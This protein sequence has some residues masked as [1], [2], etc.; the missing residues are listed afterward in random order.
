MKS[1]LRLL[2]KWIFSLQISH[3]DRLRF[4]GPVVIMPNHV[5]FLDAILLYSFLPKSA[6]FVVNLEIAENPLVSFALRFCTHIKIDPRNPY[7]LRKIIALVKEDVPVILFPEGRISVTGSMMKMYTGAAMVA[8]KTGARVFP[9]IFRGPE[10]SKFSRIKDKV[11]SLWFPDIRIFV[12]LPQKLATD[13]NMSFRAQKESLGNGLL[14]IMQQAMF[15]ARSEQYKGLDFFARLAQAS[16]LHGLDKVI[17]RDISRA[18]TYRQLLIGIYA[19]SEKIK[20]KIRNEETIVVG[21][22]MPNA[23]AHVMALFS[24]FKLGRTPAVFNFSTGTKNVVDCAKNAGVK[25]VLT[26]R[27]FV[28]KAGLGELIQQLGEANQVLYMEDIAA[29]ISPLDKLKGAWR[30]WRGEQ[31]KGTSSSQIIL[32]TSGTEGRP[33]GVVLSHSAILSNIDQVSSLI[34]YTP[35]DRMLS[36]L[37]M[38][39]SFGLM[40]GTLLPLLGGVEVFL[41]PSPLHYRMI[42]ELAYD[43]NATLMLGTPTFLAGYG[44]VAHPYDFRCMRHLLAGGE[45]LRQPIAELWLDKF[46]IRILEGYGITET[47]PVLCINTPLSYGRGSVGKFLPG[48]EW[49]LEPVEG[50]ETGGNLFVRGPN[51]MDGYLLYDKGFQPSGDWFASGDVVSVDAAGFVTVQARLKRFAKVAG[52]MINLQ[53]VEEAAMHC[54][55]GGVHAV[56]AISDGRKGERILLFTTLKTATKSVIRDYLSQEGRGLLY[57]PAE[58]IHIEKMPLLGSGKPDYLRLQTQAAQLVSE[59]PS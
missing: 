34:D 21:V 16:L 52:E 19:L 35:A 59:Q 29:T 4:E 44:K 15:Q 49:R 5:S 6:C 3:E 58:I 56:V 24:L 28:E 14:S 42:P 31:G 57:L 37:P 30:L 27:A 50:I 40:A 46:G 53:A 38:F 20:A 2:F 9:I 43:F 12:D 25:T 39:H 10:Y 11:R 23:V 45:K 55:S 8:W 47:G 48:I 33:K 18:V 54:F 36:A 13:S 32:F 17:A 26:S 1:I 41:Y 51:L 22:L 7:G